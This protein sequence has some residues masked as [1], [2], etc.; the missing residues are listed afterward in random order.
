MEEIAAESQALVDKLV[1]MVKANAVT[2]DVVPSHRATTDDRRAA[3]VKPDRVRHCRRCHR[4]V[5]R[6][7][8]SDDTITLEHGCRT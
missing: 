5:L 4:L 1:A 7:S 8:I 2:P 6:F 3:K